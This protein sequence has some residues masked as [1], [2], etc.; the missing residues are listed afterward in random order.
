MEN[1]KSPKR[2]FLKKKRGKD[3]NLFHFLIKLVGGVR[4]EVSNDELQSD[5][6]LEGETPP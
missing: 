1:M 4:W 5:F 2:D 6:T 3:K